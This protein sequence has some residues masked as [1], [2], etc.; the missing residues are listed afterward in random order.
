MCPDA[1]ELLEDGMR[2]EKLGVLDR[3]LDGFVAAAALAA[4][5]DIRSRAL[6][7]QSIVL[8]TQCRWPEA[9]EVAR[10]SRAVAARASLPVRVAEAYIAEANVHLARGRFDE[11]LP[12]FEEVLASTDDPRLR[13][14]ALQNIGSIQAQ[15]GMLDAA[16]ASF[17]ESFSC[18][19]AAGYLRGQAIA[20]NNQGRAALDGGDAHAAAPILEE[21]L[22]LAREVEDGEL[23]GLALLNLAEAMLPLHATRAEELAAT[24]LGH[25]RTSGNHWRHVEALRLLG[26]INSHRGHDDEALA[27]WRR[28]LALSRE[29]DSMVESALLQARLAAHPGPSA[30]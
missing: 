26:D 8:R 5:P 16:V 3:A 7:R 18:F 17:G 23:I 25:F 19:E 27:C 24:A 20:R 22:V 2:S 1:A 28:G 12:T 9:L 13:G 6:T 21:A 14:I 10:Q 15:G 11:A 4:D 30:G 29:I